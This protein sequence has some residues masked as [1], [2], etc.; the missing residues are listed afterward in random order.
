[1]SDY[2]LTDGT[3]PH[4]VGALKVLN[5]LLDT[6][7]KQPNPDALLSARLAPDMFPFTFQVYVACDT[8]SKM[9]ARLQGTEPKALASWEEIKTVDDARARVAE[10]QALADKAEAATIASRADATVT[11][12]MGA[13]K[14]ADLRARDY[15]AG[16]SVPNIFF[17][18]TTAYAILRKEGVQVGK[19]DYLQHFLGRYL[20]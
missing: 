13:G 7:A 3:L 17:H 18:V 5:H 4:A 1:M 16:Y 9:L 12:G 11:F 6:V 8:I 14:S 15:A 20:Q 2:T 19:Q 10:V